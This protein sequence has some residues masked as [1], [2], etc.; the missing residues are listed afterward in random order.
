MA[1]WYGDMERARGG[2][3]TRTGEL[4]MSV[5]VVVGWTH[6]S[7]SLVGIFVSI[8]VSW[9]DFDWTGISGGGTSGAA[10]AF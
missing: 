8:A 7:G 6:L 1:S 10:A 9:S 4:R 3:I 5:V 2:G